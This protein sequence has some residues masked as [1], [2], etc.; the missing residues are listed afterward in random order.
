MLVVPRRWVN[1]A[2]L[3]RR[4]ANYAPLTPL[5]W[6]E[7]AAKVYGSKIAVE[8]VGEDTKRTWRETRDRSVRLSSALSRLGYGRGDVVQV[9]LDNT[10]EMVEAHFGVP[11]SGATLGSINTRLDA[12]TV[13]Y[14]VEHSDAKCLIY[15]RK[16]ESVVPTGTKLIPLDEYEA[17]LETGSPDE[18]TPPDDEWDALSLNYT[19]GTTGNP[20]GVVLHHRGAYLDALGNAVAFDDWNDQAK[21]LWTL[22]L[23][24]CNGWYFPYAIAAVGATNVCMRQVTADTIRQGIEDHGVTHLCGAPIV[25]RFATEAMK[26]TEDRHTVHMMVA[27]APPPPAT[28]RAAEAV[29]LRVTHVYGLT[30]VYGPSALCQWKREWNDL[31]TDAQAKMKARQGVELVT[32]HNLDVVKPGTNEPVPRD[33]ETL[34]EVVF[35]GNL[36]MKGYFK[37]P[38]ATDAAFQGGLFRTGDLA[39]VDPDNYIAIKDRAKDVVISGGENISSIEVEAALV[40]HPGIREAAVVPRPDAVWGEHPCAFVELET[41]ASLTETEVIAHARTKLAGFKVPKTVVFE[42]LPKTSTG[43]VQK[44]V[45]RDRARQL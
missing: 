44:F 45:L 8:V 7:R 28:L 9:L 26:M 39:V 14:I 4:A 13:K 25:L 5:V 32:C 19:S 17:L 35:A 22:P 38:E 33:G 12:A 42:P 11:M 34:G 18:W 16:Y 37:N 23:F 3:G 31:D 15:D 27:A 1:T 30:E 21:Y 40:D 43:K 24:H 20:K 2:D 10:P 29:G 36:V 6:L 41:D